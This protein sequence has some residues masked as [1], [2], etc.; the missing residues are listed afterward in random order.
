MTEQELKEIEDLAS[1]PAQKLTG[2]ELK[3]VAHLKALITE[4]RSLQQQQ[5]VRQTPPYQTGV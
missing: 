2:R 4:V 1:L 3:M 5:P